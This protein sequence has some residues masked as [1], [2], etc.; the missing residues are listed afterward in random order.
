[1][2]ALKER[3]GRSLTGLGDRIAGRSPAG[4]GSKAGGG[5]GESSYA[6]PGSGGAAPHPDS[7]VTV[8]VRPSEEE[9]E[10]ALAELAPGYF[11]PPDAFDALEHELRCLP[12]DFGAGQLE[13]AAEART[14]VLEVR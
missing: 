13:E 14:G 9:V 8:G 1:M 3:L 7:G 5:G 11:Q 6:R 12:V 2:S 10:S 4:G